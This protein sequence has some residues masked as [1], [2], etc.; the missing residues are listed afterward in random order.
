VATKQIQKMSKGVSRSKNKKDQFDRIREHLLEGR[1]L[2]RKNDNLVLERCLHIFSLLSKGYTDHEILKICERAFEIKKSMIYI[3]IRRTKKLFGDV[4][5]SNKAA[6]KAIAIQMAKESY[7]I[8]LQI[9]RPGAMVAATKL[10]AQLEGTL[11]D[12]QNLTIIYQNLTLPP[13][14][15]S[16]DPSVINISSQEVSVEE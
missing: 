12:S 5:V 9:K 8:A 15:I 6:E 4:Q 3:L 7:K 16:D 11:S 2:P 1:N 10:I 13:I 14:E